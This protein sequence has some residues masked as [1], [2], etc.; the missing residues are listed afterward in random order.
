MKRLRDLR[1]HKVA[2]VPAGANPDAFVV[3]FK[4]KDTPPQP[5]AI[6]P[7]EEKPVKKIQDMTQ[8][9]LVAYATELE[10]SKAPVEEPKPEVPEAVQKMLD[11]QTEEIKKAT[12]RAEAAENAA[13][14]EKEARER[15]EFVVVAK[16]T[17]PHL[18]GQDVAKGHL[19]Y[20]ISKGVAKDTYD[21]LITLLKAGE[22]ATVKALNE[23]GNDEGS[24]TGSAFE[25]IE[26]LAKALV[27]DGKADTLAKAVDLVAQQNPEL[28]QEYRAENR[29]RVV[30]N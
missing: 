20:E 10:K 29:R 21:A 27:K 23:I 19:L 30:V 7:Q 4:A 26:T 24:I 12:A 17:I 15:A 9:E 16:A 11:A 8:E 25:K 22:E 28:Y 18:P 3:L 2:L 13:K 1:V 14:V 5:G 6:P